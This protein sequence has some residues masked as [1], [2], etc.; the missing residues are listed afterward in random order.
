MARGRVPIIGVGAAVWKE[1]RVLM[2]R[3]ANE[4][5]AGRWSIPGG[6][7][8]FGET[9]EQAMLREVFEETAVRCVPVALIG[10]Y[11]AFV[12]NDKGQISDHFC[13]INYAANWLFGTP[14]AGDDALEA[15]FMTLSEINELEL[16]GEVRGVIRDSEKFT[17]SG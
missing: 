16:W 1:D 5:G 6:R 9:T 15:C 4:P 13:L 14:V 10:V 7:L 8:E 3:R 11:D 17:R 2:I 12:R